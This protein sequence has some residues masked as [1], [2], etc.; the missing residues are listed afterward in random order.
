MFTKQVGLASLVVALSVVG[1]AAAPQ[2][3]AAA[4]EEGNVGVDKGVDTAARKL[5]GK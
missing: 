3:A 4:T 1:H 2:G 5:Q